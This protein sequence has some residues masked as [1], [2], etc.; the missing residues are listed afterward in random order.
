MRMVVEQLAQTQQGRTQKANRRSFD[1]GDKS[2]TYAQDD[3]F[4]GGSGYRGTTRARRGVM[5]AAMAASLASGASA[6]TQDVSPAPP[7][8]S[9]PVL[10]Q[11]GRTPEAP[12][13]GLVRK[14]PYR[15][16]LTL[17]GGGSSS[18]AGQELVLSDF[19]F[20]GD[21]VQTGK[22]HFRQ[23][24]PGVVE[25]TSMAYKVGYWRFSVT[26]S[27]NYYGLGERF[28]ALNHSHTI[29]RNSSTDDAHA[30]GSSTYKAMPFF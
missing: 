19:E 22:L 15:V 8:Q 30:K 26:D 7:P 6:Q 20:E 27:G 1:Y 3:S 13:E 14:D 5:I 10:A 12:V 17:P 29:V 25:I 2:A 16:A 11:S 23:L 4:T 18:V 21:R 28:N 24:S 9:S